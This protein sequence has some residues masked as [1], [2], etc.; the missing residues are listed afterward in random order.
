MIIQSQHPPHTSLPNT[1]IANNMLHDL[2][3]QTVI[4]HP[5]TVVT[6]CLVFFSFEY[7]RRRT[8]DSIH[9]LWNKVLY[10]LCPKS[11]GWYFFPAPQV[12]V[13]ASLLDTAAACRTTS[14][15][16]L[17]PLPSISTA[18]QQQTEEIITM[19][20]KVGKEVILDFCLLFPIPEGRRR[21]SNI[22]DRFCKYVFGWDVTS[23]KNADQK[24]KTN[25]LDIIKD[26]KLKQ[27][28]IPLIAELKK[29]ISRHP[30]DIMAYCE[31][32]SN[33]IDKAQHQ[34]LEQA[35]CI[36]SLSRF[37]SQ[38]E[39]MLIA[40]SG[41]WWT[42][43]LAT[44]TQYPFSKIF[45][46]NEY[47][48]KDKLD[49]QSQ[50]LYKEEKLFEPMDLP[51]TVVN[52]E[53]A[54]NRDAEELTESQ[55]LEQKQRSE[56]RAKYMGTR[57]SHLPRA[58]QAW[59][60]YSDFH[61]HI[62]KLGSS[63]LYTISEV[64]NFYKQWYEVRQEFAVAQAPLPR[65]VQTSSKLL[66]FQH[67]NMSNTE[68]IDL[69]R[70]KNHWSPALQLGTEISNRY[71]VAIWEIL[72]SQLTENLPEEERSFLETVIYPGFQWVLQK[73]KGKGKGKGKDVQSVE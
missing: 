72:D 73:V 65:P 61:D 56:E 18:G 55:K 25:A 1:L 24:Q 63:M 44:R 46:L 27:M 20:G 21:S 51:N 4:V 2:F 19:P 26:L 6:L 41:E 71:L 38:K 67:N 13:Y 15:T 14:S 69:E 48:D 23:Y 54:G 68:R 70:F 40:A 42:F 29:P 31:Y 37:R 45:S 8:E 59:K 58:N 60:K 30:P 17:E 57:S 34:L 64:H 52:V 50:D 11:R 39:I 22:T 36:F 43:R 12:R 33:H 32:L 7:N 66:K 53:D 16:N 62:N 3:S 49:E 9:V 35:R 5:L 10:D 28:T 47:N